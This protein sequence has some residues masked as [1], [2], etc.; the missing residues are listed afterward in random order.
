MSNRVTM[1]KSQ[2]ASPFG[3][4]LIRHALTMSEDGDITQ[5]EV[6][7]LLQLLRRGPPEF[8]CVAFLRSQCE[9]VLVDGTVSPAE[10]FEIKLAVERALPKWFR[11]EFAGRTEGIVP[12]RSPRARTEIEELATDRQL[13]YIRDLGGEVDGRLSKQQASDLISVLAEKRPPSPRQRMVL[14]F[15]D[16]L[17]LASSTKDEVTAWM[18]EFYDQD[19]RR[20]QAWRRFKEEIGDDG[21]LRDETVVPLGAGFRYL[22][23]GSSLQ[24]GCRSSLFIVLGA[25]VA[26]VAIFAF[27]TWQFA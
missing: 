16:R 18:T 2:A 3:Q 5:E 12:Y 4:E 25:I 22:T 20:E 17:D 9:A 13:A 10:Q 24:R 8:A 27:A 14:R 15:W 1:T 23:S 19:P 26:G 7:L 6:V 21:S 11:E